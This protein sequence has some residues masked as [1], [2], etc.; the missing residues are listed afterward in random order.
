MT[1]PPAFRSAALRDIER[2]DFIDLA[3]APRPLGTPADPAYWA[4]EVF[5]MAHAPFAVRALMALRQALV[6]IVGIPRGSVTTFAVREV[7]GDEAL[8]GTDDVHLQFRVGVGV[9]PQLVR[10]TTVVRLHGWRGRLYFLPVRLL[11]SVVVHAMLHAAGRRL[12]AAAPVSLPE[13]GR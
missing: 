8:L 12:A 4:A 9:D 3:A 5:S 1:E 2:P 10:V 6:S 7:V 11:H 13:P